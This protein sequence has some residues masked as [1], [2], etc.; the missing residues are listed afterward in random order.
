MEYRIGDFAVITRLSIKVLRN[1]HEM[2]LLIPVR[3]IP[4]TGYRYYDENQ[5][6][7]ARII[8]TLKSWNFSL[9]EIKEILSEYNEDKDLIEIIKNKQLEIKTEIEK[10]TKIEEDL[11]LLIN[12]EE[13][14]KIM[15]TKNEITIKEIDELKIIFITYRGRYDECGKYMGQLYRAAGRKL[16]GTVFNMYQEE[17]DHDN[18]EITVCLPV[19]EKI[20]RQGIEFR[21]LPA[22]R[23]LSTIHYGP[24]DK[25]GNSYQ[26]LIDH[27]EELGLKQAGP[28]REIYRKGPGMLFAG[29]A[30]KYVTEIQ[31][32]IER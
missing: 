26:K 10:L 9:K 11:T 14:K 24:Y 23:A 30:K 29:N 6:Q 4:E 13:E 3:I 28:Y 16:A 8:S 7:R 21:I 12:I 17:I 32:E 1:Y 27:R 25:L 2:G 18:P 5:I 31:M 15:D 20:E 22:T 19:K